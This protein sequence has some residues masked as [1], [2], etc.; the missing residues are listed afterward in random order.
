MKRAI[1]QAVQRAVA[2]NRGTTLRP[3]PWATDQEIGPYPGQM[4]IMPGYPRER[5]PRRWFP[6][7]YE[8]VRMAK[9]ERWLYVAYRA[10]DFML[11]HGEGGLYPIGE[12]ARKQQDVIAWETE[13]AWLARRAGVLEEF[14]SPLLPQWQA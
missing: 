11:Q 4:V 3:A 8:F 5:Q 12:Y 7:E 9:L 6:A 14:D 1:R 2:E 10:L 13:L